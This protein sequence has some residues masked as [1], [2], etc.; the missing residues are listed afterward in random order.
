M[1]HNDDNLQVA[2]L[3]FIYKV[4]CTLQKSEKSL[5]LSD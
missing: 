2:K 1:S 5:K 3:A 4:D